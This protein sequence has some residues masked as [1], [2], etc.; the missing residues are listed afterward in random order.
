VLLYAD[1]TVLIAESAQTLQ[2]CLNDFGEYCKTWKLKIN[3]D[4][5]KVI[6][7]GSRQNRNFS[8]KIDNTSLEIVNSYKYLCFFSKIW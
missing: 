4:K 3:K 7:F 8:F 5:T 1:D 6:I 2:N